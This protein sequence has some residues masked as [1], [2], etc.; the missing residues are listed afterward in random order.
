[1]TQSQVSRGLRASGPPV[2]FCQISFVCNTVLLHNAKA[3]F[4]NDL[5][6]LMPC[7]SLSCPPGQL[8]PGGQANRGWL[9]PGGQAVQ[10]AR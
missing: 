5:L 1:M 7:N 2:I 4:D 6:I 10:G 9:A 8:A 3:V